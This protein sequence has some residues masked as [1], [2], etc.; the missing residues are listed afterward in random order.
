M[1]AVRPWENAGIWRRSCTDWRTWRL[2]RWRS[3]VPMT[4]LLTPTWAGSPSN[5]LT[6]SSVRHAVRVLD[7]GR[8]ADRIADEDRPLAPGG[9]QQAH[10][11]RRVARRVQGGH[12]LAEDAVAVGQVEDAQGFQRRQGLSDVAGGDG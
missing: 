9:D 5:R 6:A 11:A 2:R 1:P 8:V 4:W 10:A 3:R 7:L 12:L